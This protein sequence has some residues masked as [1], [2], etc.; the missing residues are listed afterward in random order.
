MAAIHGMV[1]LLAQK[2]SI[3]NAGGWPSLRVGVEVAGA[4][5]LVVFE[6]SEGLIFPGRKSK[7]RPFQRLE[8]SATRKT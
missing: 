4:R 2:V 1:F 7:P 5:S 8:E 6:G 3:I